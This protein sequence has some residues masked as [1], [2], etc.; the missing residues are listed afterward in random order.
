MSVK[1]CFSHFGKSMESGCLRTGCLG[2]YLNLTGMK[3]TV[4]YCM[5]RSSI[6]CNLLLSGVIRMTK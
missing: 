3:D 2:V 1:L 4:N 6:I 5:K